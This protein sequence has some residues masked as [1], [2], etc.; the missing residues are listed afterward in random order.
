[1]VEKVNNWNIGD[2]IKSKNSCVLYEIKYIHHGYE[3]KTFSTIRV[4]NVNTGK[5]HTEFL[6][7]MD[8]SYV[9][10]GKCGKGLEIL[11][12]QK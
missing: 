3:D 6:L 9:N 12:H 2:I 8:H 1:M 11:W 10:L 5:L 4:E 7:F